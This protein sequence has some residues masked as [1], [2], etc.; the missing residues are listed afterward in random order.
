MSMSLREQQSL[1]V[2]LIGVLIAWC[3]E[4][5][6][7]LTFSEAWRSP[8][9]AAIQAAK[10]AG[11]T[12]SL[13]TQRLAIDLNLFKN[14]VLQDT[15]EQYQ[16]LGEVWEKLHELARWGGRWKHTDADHF[17]LTYGGVS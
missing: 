2:R 17:S 10:G 16:P 5:G 15:V 14:G 6:Y 12:H 8:E 11:V 7:E 9:E 4:N 3:Y 13:H 1:F